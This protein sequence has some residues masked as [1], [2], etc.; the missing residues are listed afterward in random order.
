M[1]GYRR[2][3]KK[4]NGIHS[5]GSEAGGTKKKFMWTQYETCDESNPEE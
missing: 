2:A 1:W 4:D 3:Y 5:V